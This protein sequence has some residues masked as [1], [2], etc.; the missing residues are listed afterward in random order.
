MK[1]ILGILA[2]IVF[3]FVSCENESDV[4]SDI[5]K[6][7]QERQSLKNMVYSLEKDKAELNKHIFNLTEE[8]KVLEK[9]NDYLKEGK[10]P[11]YIVK[12]QLKQSHISLD[13]G[14]HLKDE[15][16]KIEFELPVSEEFYNE[17]EPGDNIV[18]KYRTGSLVLYGSLGKWKMKVLSK[19]IR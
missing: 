9:K 1:R 11:K 17:I 4:Q 16:N 5:D 2:L 7:R 13:L 19:S 18:D 3:L 15:M 12:F 8:S 6:L 14:K 10:T